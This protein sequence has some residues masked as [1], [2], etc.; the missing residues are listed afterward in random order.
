MFY[1]SWFLISKRNIFNKARFQGQYEFIYN[2]IFSPQGSDEKHDTV[3]SNDREKKLETR[4][5]KI[6]LIGN[7]H[8]VIN[9]KYI[10]KLEVKSNILMKTV[11]QSSLANVVLGRQGAPGSKNVFS[12]F[13]ESD[14]PPEASDEEGDIYEGF[15]NNERG[16]RSYHAKLH[17]TLKMSL[18]TGRLIFRYV[19]MYVL[20]NVKFIMTIFRDNP[21][22]KLQ[23][24]EKF[25]P[26]NFTFLLP[27]GKNPEPNISSAVVTKQA[28]LSTASKAVF[29]YEFQR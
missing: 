27:S 1:Y 13:V 12:S 6:H 20:L 26:A 21:D 14:L 9:H 2:C 15:D 29:A 22:G 7:C 28:N 3:R 18:V 5:L 17:S 19:K 23:Q 16:Q 25:I 4:S 24:E 8:R 11:T 10:S